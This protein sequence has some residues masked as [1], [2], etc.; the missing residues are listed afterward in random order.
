MF[1]EL[2]NVYTEVIK[3]ATDDQIPVHL[4]NLI[5]DAA[6]VA[7]AVKSVMNEIRTRIANSQP[8]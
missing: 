2:L 7:D 4:E 8:Q 1:E 5:K 3:A 6:A